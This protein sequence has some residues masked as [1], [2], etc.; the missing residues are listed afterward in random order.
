MGMIIKVENLSYQYSD[1][2]PIL[3]NINIDIKR[4]TIHG[5][6]GPNGSGKSTLL[7]CLSNIYRNYHGCIKLN[8]K[9]L[10]KM[11]CAESAQWISYV[12]QDV[13]TTFP[14]TVYEILAMSRTVHLNN[15]IFL[16]NNDKEI[17]ANT[18]NEF[19]IEGIQKEIYNELSGGQKQKVLIARAVCQGSS[20][21]ILDEPTASLDFK[22]Q[23]LIWKTLKTLNSKG[24]TI[25]ISSH[26]PNHINLFCDQVTVV[27]N[28]EIIQ[29]GP[30]QQVFNYETLY[31]LYQDTFSIQNNYIVPKIDE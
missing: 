26:D 21:I 29:H 4:N 6:F 5:I 18:M 27:L 3:Q 2:K 31:S 17:I 23:I 25:I 28:G 9:E 11:S 24:K 1:R 19:S 12:P 16:A 20:I 30:T 10:N 13:A 14:Y 22:N 7:K 15:H 8:K